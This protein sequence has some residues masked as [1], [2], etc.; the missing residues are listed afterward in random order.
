MALNGNIKTINSFLDK[1]KLRVAAQVN[2]GNGKILK[3]YLPDRELS[4]L[5]PR[6]ILTGKSKDVPRELLFTIDPM[7][8]RLA[9]GRNVR[10]WQYEQHYYFSFL[11]WKNV[12]FQSD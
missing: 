8:R 9:A 6:S 11:S 1:D 10:L 3:A 12:R 2:T 4:A 5:L 7:I